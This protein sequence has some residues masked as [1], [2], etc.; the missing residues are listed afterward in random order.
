MQEMWR[1]FVWAIVLVTVVPLFFLLTAGSIGLQWLAFWATDLWYRIR[2]IFT[3][4][5]TYH[6]PTWRPVGVTLELTA[7]PSTDYRCEADHSRV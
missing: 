1:C 2:P 5:Y 6:P 7:G 3:R 4:R